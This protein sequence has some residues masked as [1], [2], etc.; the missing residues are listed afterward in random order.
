MRN[1]ILIIEDDLDLC[2]ALAESFEDEGFIVNHRQNGMLGKTELEQG[3]YDLLILDIKIPGLTGFGILEWLKKSGYII[4]TIVLTGMPLHEEITKYLNE[5][6][7]KEAELLKYAD[8]VINKPVKTE[9]LIKNV[10]ELI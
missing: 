6:S 2:E 7:P 9:L 3:D 5:D 1:R 4:K 8:R 10:K